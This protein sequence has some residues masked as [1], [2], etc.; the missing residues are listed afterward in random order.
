MERCSLIL[1]LPGKC[2]TAYFCG[3]GRDR[4]IRAHE[5]RKST[6][7]NRA[8][9]RQAIEAHKQVPP[10]IAE[11]S[12]SCIRSFRLRTKSLT[13]LLEPCIHIWFHTRLIG[14]LLLIPQRIGDADDI[15]HKIPVVSCDPQPFLSGKLHIS[16][17][18]IDFLP[19][20]PPWSYS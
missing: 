13:A 10:L 4:K 2:K 19:K 7:Y 20:P 5:S 14:K 18:S 15:S 11:K 12:P 9:D 3:N 8:N 16:F 1:F 17:I 6:G